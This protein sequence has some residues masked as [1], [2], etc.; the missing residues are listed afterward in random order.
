MNSLQ[1]FLAL[2][3]ITLFNPPR[4]LSICDLDSQFVDRKKLLLLLRLALAPSFLFV[5]SVLACLFLSFFLWSCPE[6]LPSLRLD[7]GLKLLEE[8]PNPILPSL[9]LEL[10]SRGKAEK[11]IR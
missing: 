1:S 4:I 2:L 10:L 11:E 6:F 5:L 3:P 9:P 7:L 8:P